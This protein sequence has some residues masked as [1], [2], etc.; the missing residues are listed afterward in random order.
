MQKRRKNV[1]KE[2][3]LQITFMHCKRV[4]GKLLKFF[5]VFGFHFQFFC[6]GNIFVI[7]AIFLE[8]NL[9]SVANYLILSLAMADLLVAILVMPLGAIYQVKWTFLEM[10]FISIEEGVGAVFVKINI[11]NFVK[12]ERY[13]YIEY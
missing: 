1:S 11:K 12:K 3:E 6:S 4:M 5:S 13:C 8:R 10:S 9:Q 7:I 2:R